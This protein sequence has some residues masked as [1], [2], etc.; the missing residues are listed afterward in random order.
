MIKSFNQ[1]FSPPSSVCALP[2][3]TFALSYCRLWWRDSNEN[4]NKYICGAQQIFRALG[5][6]GSLAGATLKP[7]LFVL[8]IADEEAFSLCSV[9]SSYLGFVFGTTSFA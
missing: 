4:T 2:N 9:H 3:T 6:R 7:Q 8:A 1:P 5:Q